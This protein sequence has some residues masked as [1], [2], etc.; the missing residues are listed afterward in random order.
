MWGLGFRIWGLDLGYRGL[1]ELGLNTNL[2][3]MIYQVSHQNYRHDLEVPIIG[4]YVGV[5]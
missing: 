1:K 2:G 5:P 3:N 4:V